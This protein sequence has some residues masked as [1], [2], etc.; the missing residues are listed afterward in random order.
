METR[1]FLPCS[2]T[3]LP[4]VR[5]LIFTDTVFNSFFLSRHVENHLSI[6]WNGNKFICR[7]FSTFSAHLYCVK[8][9]FSCVQSYFASLVNCELKDSHDVHGYKRDGKSLKR[10]RRKECEKGDEKLKSWQKQSKLASIKWIKN[11]TTTLHLINKCGMK[12]RSLKM[13]IQSM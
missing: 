12:I 1:F 2:S 6:Q 11:R 9:H 4:L 8:F 5:L 3:Q 13:V 7:M 10:K